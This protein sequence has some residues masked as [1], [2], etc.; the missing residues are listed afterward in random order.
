MEIQGNYLKAASMFMDKNALRRDL[1]G[2][3]AEV[4]DTQLILTATDGHR[5]VSIRLDVE[6]GQRTTKFIIPGSLLKDV[7]PKLMT[8]LSI[9]DDDKLITVKQ[10]DWAKQSA[11]LDGVFPAYRRVIPQKI[12]GEAANY[13]PQYLLDAAKAV[14]MLTGRSTMSLAM[15]HNGSDAGVVE[16]NDSNVIM[17]I[18][19]IISKT[20]FAYVKPSW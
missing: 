16:I 18:M 14:N 13:N 20:E 6:P 7:K 1:N 19:P 15:S 8:Y 11:P 12:S 17:I 4:S 10:E 9:S 2:V 5:M 3:Y